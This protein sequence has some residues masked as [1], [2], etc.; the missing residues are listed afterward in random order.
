MTITSTIH[1]NNNMKESPMTITTAATQDNVVDGQI[2]LMDPQSTGMDFTIVDDHTGQPVIV[3]LS[4]DD[5]QRLSRFT[6]AI[7]ECGDELATMPQGD[8]MVF[9][10]Y[11]A[12]WVKANIH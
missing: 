11:G 3:R 12:A 6:K 1:L 4:L 10:P 8:R 2:V 7:E 9:T 5:M